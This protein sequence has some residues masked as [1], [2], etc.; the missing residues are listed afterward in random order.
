MKI[1]IPHHLAL[2]REFNNMFKAFCEL[3][4]KLPGSHDPEYCVNHSFAF[5]Y[6]FVTC[7]QPYVIHKQLRLLAKISCFIKREKLLRNPITM[8]SFLILLFLIL[9]LLVYQIYHLFPFILRKPACL[10]P[11]APITKLCQLKLPLIT[12]DWPNLRCANQ[13]LP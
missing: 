5:L 12:S 1:R 2:K 3:C 6:H 8:S 10:L 11:T 9:A 4:P 13:I 7:I